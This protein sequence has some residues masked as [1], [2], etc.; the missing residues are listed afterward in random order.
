MGRD[1]ARRDKETWRQVD[2]SV[3][4]IAV[5][6]FETDPFAWKQKPEPFAVGFYDGKTFT[7][8]WGDD[9]VDRVIEYLGTLDF[10]HMIFAHNGGK[11]DFYFLL[12]YI[13]GS[14]KIVKGRIL[15]CRIG[16]HEFRDSWGILPFPLK[17]YEKD[18]IDYQKFTRDNREANREEIVT[19]LKGDCV[20]LFDLVFEF[21]RRFG[22]SLTIGSM[23]LRKLG[24]HHPFERLKE[25]QDDFLREFNFGGRTQCFKTGIIKGDWK[26]YDVNAMY[27]FVM[28]TFKHPIASQYH[29]GDKITA[30]TCFV[31]FAGRNNGALPHRGE[32]GLDFTRERGTFHASI[33]EIEAA[34]DLGLIQIDR[35]IYTVD[36]Y[37]RT[38]FAEFVEEY[39]ALRRDAQAKG[40]AAGNLLYKYLLNSSYGKFSQNPDNHAEYQIAD[41]GELSEPW[42]PCEMHGPYM[43][44]QKPPRTRRYFNVATGA[45][46]TGA[47]RAL[48]LR[49]IAAATVPAYCDTDSIICQALDVPIDARKLGAWKLEASGDK[50]AIAGKKM[51]AVFQGAKCIKQASKGVRL[52]PSEI[53]SVAKGN[54]IQYANP[55]PKFKRDGGATFIKRTIRMTAPL[56]DAAD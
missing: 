16:R 8:F 12:K 1:T 37:E 56:A 2:N 42:Q 13:K 36:F 51:Y 22:D 10:P 15:Q 29:V 3:V 34:Q 52:T 23:A 30:D 45:S 9:C 40:D 11:F 33:H 6:D 32:N 20:Y 21:F 38:T 24:T 17:E 18:K 53:V 4:R 49:G 31:C 41:V 46:I 5:L 47:A 14:V 50:L 44:Y 54:V 7:H 48:L 19:Y 28:S 25:P 35:V 43:L 27:P 55:V 26:V 39:H